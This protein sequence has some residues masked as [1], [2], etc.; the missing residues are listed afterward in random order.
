M[1]P[2]F[3]GDA[4]PAGRSALA[5]EPPVGGG[6]HL[7]NNLFK[8]HAACYLTHAGIEAC[9]QLKHA[10]NIVPDRIKRVVMRLDHSVDRICNIPSPKT[11]LEAS[12]ACGRRRRWRSAVSIRRA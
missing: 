9:R 4:Q 10:H 6:L 3:R 1:P 5:F 11:G 12:S 7:R 2:G 8:Y